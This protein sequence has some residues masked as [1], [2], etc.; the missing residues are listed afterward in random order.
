MTDALYIYI[1][2]K[3]VLSDSALERLPAHLAERARRQWEHFASQ[4]AVMEKE[5][6]FC[7]KHHIQVLCYTDAE[8]PERLK[9]LRDAPL[10][11]FYLGN[12]P[13]N[14]RRIVSIVGTRH[15]TPYGKELCAKI[16]GEIAKLMPDALIVSGLAYGADIHAH[17]GALA[18]G[19][20][21]VAV[22]A[23]GLDRIYPYVHKST[24][25]QMTRQG[26]LLTEYPSCTEPERHNFVHRN[27][28]VAAMADCTIVVESAAHGG[29]MITLSRAQE[30]GKRVWACPGRLTDIYSAGCNNAIA[31]GRAQSFTSV[32]D[33]VQQMGW[34][35]A[36]APDARQQSLF[37]TS[38]R[39]AAIESLSA[40]SL[41]IISALR[42][43]E[44][45]LPDAISTRTG[46][47]A[48]VVMAELME[49]E[50]RGIVSLADGG[51]ARISNL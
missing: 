10:V 18:S 34:T 20:S 16:T 22:L 46:L 24:A 11:L 25:A 47:S 48:H 43:E 1:K 50:M 42:Q 9:I 13:L 26:G 28:I 41:Q 15:I 36:A 14:T 21:T 12:A 5:L 29:S 31:E 17:R 33:L 19:L 32:A 35:G 8:Y 6:D 45:M 27:R 37:D 7:N 2:G 38:E 44:S 30:L 39:D 40:E 4:T 49:L 51:E 23:H 3:G